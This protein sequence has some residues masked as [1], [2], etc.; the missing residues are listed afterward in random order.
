MEKAQDIRQRLEAY[1]KAKFPQRKELSVAEMEQLTAGISRENY[2][3]TV[4]WREAKGPACESLIIQIDLGFSDSVLVEAEPHEFGPQ[5]EVLKRVQGTGIPVPKVY[6]VE[7]DSDVLGHPFCIMEKIEGEVLGEGYYVNHPEHQPQLVKDYVEILAKIHT[8]DWQ[9]LG[10]SFLG[11]PEMDDQRFQ[12]ALAGFQRLAEE[13]QYCPQPVMA[14][15][16]TWLK[17]NMPQPERTALCHGDY[18]LRNIL[19][20]DGRI[21]ALLDWEAVHL[22][23]PMSDLAWSCLFLKIGYESFCNET[24][25]ISAYEEMAG[26]KVD[27]ERLLFWQVV[28]AVGLMSVGLAGIKTGIESKDPDMRQLWIWPTVLPRVGDAAARLLGF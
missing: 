18:H 9:A 16:L 27:K 24:D 11:V 5:Y 15:L 1:L 7:T 22:G 28:A 13:S 25:F 26:V 8:L 17:R 12:M 20:R 23:D 6:C 10:L 2:L 14:E 19:A 21:V 4:S 3:V